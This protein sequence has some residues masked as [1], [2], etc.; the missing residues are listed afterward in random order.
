M[1]GNRNVPR[2]SVTDMYL[3][4]Y[5]VV[6]GHSIQGLHQISSSLQQD[7]LKEGEERMR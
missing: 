3:D 1:L 6:M 2:C 5:L 4:V 7:L